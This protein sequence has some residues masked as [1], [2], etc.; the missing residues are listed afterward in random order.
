[1]TRTNKSSAAR[2]ASASHL[3]PNTLLQYQTPCSIL[4][5]HTVLQYRTSRKNNVA[6]YT[7]TPY[8]STQ[9]CKCIGQ[10]STR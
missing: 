3:V 2:N 1:M 5:P 9:H 7:V 8:A 10:Y 4:V 6:R